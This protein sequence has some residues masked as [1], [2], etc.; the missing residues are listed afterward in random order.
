[1]SAYA[2]NHKPHILCHSPFGYWFHLKVHM[3][4]RIGRSRDPPQ[5]SNRLDYQRLT[6][7]RT[8][9]PGLAER[10]LSYAT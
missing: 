9:V 3:G 8:N 7:T 5:I 6:Q 4:S 2:F 10:L 1:M